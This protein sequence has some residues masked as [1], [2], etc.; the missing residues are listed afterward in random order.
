MRIKYLFLGLF[1]WALIPESQSQ[2]CRLYF[3]DET[4]VVREMKT[5]NQ[6]DR[7]QSVT[8]H[9]I[10]ERVERGNDITL[11]VRAS[12][13][14]DDME[15]FYTVDL[16]LVCEDGIFKFDM[17]NFLDPETMAG[18]EEMGIEVTADDMYYPA[19]M[20]V[21]DNLPDA[22]IE[23]VIKSNGM[24]ILTTTVSITDRK[25]EA[26]EEIE[27]EA[28]VFNCYKISYNT[29]TKAGFINVSGSAVEWIADG[30][31]VVR[32][33]TYNRRGRLSGYSVLTYL[34]K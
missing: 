30:V 22:S 8:R 14:D 5:Y 28:G 31:G 12:H 20:S 15:E 18:Y 4:G 21:G 6:R 26:M 16:E 24:T 10:I 2:E 7:L 34:G 25:V 33:E 9:E 3:P 19:G 17:K 13:L 11:T 32:S 29:G 27:T 1:V 23:M